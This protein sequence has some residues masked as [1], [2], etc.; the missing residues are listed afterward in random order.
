MKRNTTRR[1]RGR[2][3]SWRLRDTASDSRS[4]RLLGAFQEPK[5]PAG[6]RR[7]E[8]GTGVSDICRPPTPHPE[9]LAVS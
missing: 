8:E 7:A 5:D 4:R 6:D 3:L 9:E 2:K 1:K